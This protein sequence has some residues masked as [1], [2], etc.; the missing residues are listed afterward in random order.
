MAT[1]FMRKIYSAQES[2]EDNEKNQE[3]EGD[4]HDKISDEIK[5]ISHNS[6][7]F[8]EEDDSAKNEKQANVRKEIESRQVFDYS[9]ERF[10]FLLKFDKKCCLCFRAKRK[11]AD[12][13]Y[14]GAR[15]KLNE[16]LDIL[17]IVKKLRVHQFA[18]QIALK[19]H[20]R[21][22]IN[23]F[24]DFKVKEPEPEEETSQPIE[25]VHTSNQL[26]TS[27]DF[28]V[29]N[30][31]A[32]LKK[33]FKDD[34]FAVDDEGAIYRRQT[35]ALTNL[36]AAIDLLDP[37]NNDVDAKIVQRITAF[38]ALNSSRRDNMSFNLVADELTA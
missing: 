5:R 14:S 29:K 38:T 16:E 2:D 34:S 4:K 9:Y 3:N 8:D 20:Q 6:I 18:S 30:V 32:A 27:V 22:L 35:E 13:L 15:K 10:W 7:N 21:E 23:F 28:R 25:V 26:G 36:Y 12:F 37:E 1:N 31:D 11:R 19:P 17:E 33:T 24:Q